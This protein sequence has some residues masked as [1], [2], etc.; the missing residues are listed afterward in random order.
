MHRM[1]ALENRQRSGASGQY[2]HIAARSIEEL[3]DCCKILVCGGSEVRH[4]FKLPT[5]FR[6]LQQQGDGELIMVVVPGL[7]VALAEICQVQRQEWIGIS[8]EAIQSDNKANKI[9]ERIPFV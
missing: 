4:I 7:T 2:A 8:I 9:R 1:A 6:S 5:C 3:F